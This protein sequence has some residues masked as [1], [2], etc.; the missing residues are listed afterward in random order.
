MGRHTE[1]F[2][3]SVNPFYQLYKDTGTE[4]S[5]GGPS[6][7]IKGQKILATKDINIDRSKEMWSSS[8]LKK[9]QTGL[10]EVKGKI[11]IREE[12]KCLN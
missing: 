12:V 8:T 6:A 5:H 11:W 9:G 2:G 3:R 7:T 10:L 4:I 1:T